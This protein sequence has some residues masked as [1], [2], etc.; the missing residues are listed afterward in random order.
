[1]LAAL[2]T[3]VY[4]ANRSR[5]IQMQAKHMLARSEFGQALRGGAA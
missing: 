4:Y 3:I 1:M 5:Q 2:H